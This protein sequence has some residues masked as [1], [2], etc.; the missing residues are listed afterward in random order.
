MRDAIEGYLG[1]GGSLL[2]LGGNG[3][4]DCVDI[5]EDL[6]TLTVYGTY[7]IG[8]IRLFR[9]PPILRP[10]SAL[11]GVAFPWSSSGGDVGN[12]AGSRVGFQVVKGDH[13]FFAGTGLANGDVF[14]TRGWCVTEDAGSLEGGGAS[15]W[16]CDARDALTPPLTVLLARGMNS[17]PAAEMVTYDH[18]GGGLVFSAG[19]MTIQGAIPVDA[20]LQKIVSNVLAEAKRRR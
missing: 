2:Y 16:E 1:D 18:R 13:P 11:L 5:A 9:Q 20:A 12:N 15:G 3:F 8:R 17:G 4:Y 6:S 19:S 14:G 10:E 7:G